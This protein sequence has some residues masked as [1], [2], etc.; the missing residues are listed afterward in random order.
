MTISET[1]KAFDNKIEQNSVKYNSDRQTAKS[2][3]LSSGNVSKYEFLNGKDVLPEK[4]LLGKAATRKRFEYSP[5]RKEL[6]AQTGIAKDQ[7]KKQPICAT[8]WKIMKFIA[9]IE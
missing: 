5:L 1:F 2:F 3:T 6:Q 7:Y 9:E 4:D 8:R